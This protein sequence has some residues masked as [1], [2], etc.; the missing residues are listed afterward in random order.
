MNEKYV[1]V[2]LCPPCVCAALAAL[3]IYSP[4]KTVIWYLAIIGLAVCS[5]FWIVLKNDAQ[6]I[7]A[8]IVVAISIGMVAGARVV[9]TQDILKLTHGLAERY[10]KRVT[11]VITSN[12]GKTTKGYYK[13]T[14]RLLSV[15]GDYGSKTSAQGAC[16]LISDTDLLPG[17]LVEIPLNSDFEKGMFFVRGKDICIQKKPGVIEQIRFYIRKIVE[18]AIDQSAGKSAP[19]VKAL[20]TGYRGDLENDSVQIFM[21]AGCAHILALSGQHVAVIVLLL[22]TCIRLSIGKRFAF[23]ISVCLLIVFSWFTGASPSVVRAV[24]QFVIAGMCVRLGRPQ[25]SIIVFCY[26]F[27][28]AIVLFPET[29]Y[30]LSFKLSYLAV[31]GIILCNDVCVFMLKRWLPVFAAKALS[32]GICALAGTILISVS[33]FNKINIFSP[34]TSALVSPFVTCLI[35]GGIVGGIAVS[36]FPWLSIFPQYILGKIEAI[37]LVIIQTGGKIGVIQGVWIG[38]LYILLVIIA[39]VLYCFSICRA[40]CFKI[41]TAKKI[42]FIYQYYMSK[43]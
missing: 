10:I 20:L 9:R 31:L 28:L 38:K 8:A 18:A 7:S 42:N 33:V 34:I 41:M 2:L 23:L 27:I 11:L 4:Y 29:P 24:L 22:G 35:I 21:Q 37:M 19:L 40:R 32:Q 6:N 25:K 43:L 39:V 5:L 14:G 30:T 12:A 26:S 16:M 36:I 15:S 17:S 13:M 1:R 3:L